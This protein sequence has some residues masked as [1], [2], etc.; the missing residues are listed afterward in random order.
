M[1]QLGT[2]LA[3]L[4]EIL[5][6]S[7][8]THLNILCRTPSKLSQFSDKTTY[9]NINIIKGDIRDLSAVKSTLIDSATNLPVDIIVSSL[10]MILLRS[11]T[12]SMKWSDPSICHDGIRTIFDALSSLEGEYGAEN[13]KTKVIAVSTTGISKKGRDIPFS[14][15]PLYHL[16]K[17][18]HDD[19]KKM[20]E[21]IIK[22]AGGGKRWVVVRPS[23]LVDGEGK[24][25]VV[26]VG[27]EIPVVGESSGLGKNGGKGEDRKE[28]GHIITGARLEN[29][30]LRKLSR[31]AERVS[32][33]DVL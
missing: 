5:S 33:K 28:I 14:M 31:M 6:S 17:T 15:I 22:W 30:S 26:R 18:P 11:S 7:P 32:G 12:F 25:G 13:V 21:E 4:Q 29:G 27:W 16:G 1:T 23:L 2:G 19:K 8:N 9:P 3:V 24:K 10:G 20:E